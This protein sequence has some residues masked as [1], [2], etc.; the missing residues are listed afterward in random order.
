M[1]MHRRSE[2][3]G[4]L[5]DESIVLAERHLISVLETQ[6]DP[7]LRSYPR[8]GAIDR[9]MM[10]LVSRITPRCATIYKPVFGGTFVEET[11]FHSE[12]SDISQEGDQCLNGAAIILRN[13]FEG[14]EKY[15]YLMNEKL[16]EWEQGILA[17]ALHSKLSS[18]GIPSRIQAKLGWKRGTSFIDR[19]LSFDLEHPLLVVY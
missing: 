15:D 5:A 8:G 13:K 9:L 16:G 6:G 18:V 7:S 1:K 10:V 17:Y 12:F 11:A 2:T 4:P 19:D 14:T 3:P